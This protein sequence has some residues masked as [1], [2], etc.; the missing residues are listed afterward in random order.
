MLLPPPT[1]TC[2]EFSESQVYIPPPAPIPG[3]YRVHRTPYAREV[4]D[5]FSDPL[6][7]QVVIKGASQILK[8]TAII[9]MVAYGIAHRPSAMMLVQPKE[10]AAIT[11]S[12]ER[13]MP[14]INASPTLN[15]VVNT[16]KG[17][18]IGSTQKEIHFQNGSLVLVGA[19]S[20]TDLAS[21][22]IRYLFCDEVDRYPVSAGKEGDPVT[23]A[24]ARTMQY[25]DSKVVLVSSPGN[26]GTSRIDEAFSKT[27]QRY[28][29]V[30]CPKC[31]VFQ[32][33]VWEQ[34][35]WVQD[36]DDKGEVVRH[37]P[38][39]C[40]YLCS[41]SK[42]SHKWTDSDRWGALRSPEARW[43]ATAK[44]EGKAGFQISRLY[45]FDVKGL[46]ELVQKFIDS[47]A[48]PDLMRTFRNTIL[49]ECYSEELSIKTDVSDMLA[50]KEVYLDEVPDGVVLL[51]AAV[52]VQ[53]NRLEVLVVGW[54]RGEE[55]WAID[56]QVIAIEPEHPSAWVELEKILTK[57]WTR[58]DGHPFRIE[59]T[60]IDSGDGNRQHL[61]FQ[62]CQPREG[63][64]VRAIKGAKE[65]PGETRPTWKGV[66]KTNKA[67]KA[68]QYPVFTYLA[69]DQIYYRLRNVAAKGANYIHFPALVGENGRDPFNDE[70]FK[71][72]LFGEYPK[73]ET[74]ANRR[75][76]VWSERSSVR[77]EAFD[78]FVYNFASLRA[79]QSEKWILERL[80]GIVPPVDEAK[81][82]ARKGAVK[83][84]TASGSSP[85]QMPTA[86]KAVSSTGQRA[87][88]FAFTPMPSA[89][90]QPGRRY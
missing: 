58:R 12:K 39:T 38:D 66:P 16:H 81:A 45:S 20:P 6:C 34:V 59:H 51:T 1:M 47:Q 84:Q 53:K 11:F 17:S 71:Q 42:C 55:C 30:P 27:D 70:F 83:Q 33:M 43:V 78:L 86:A 50:R 13:L 10:G 46:A 54:G 4:L 77:N 19:E 9:N 36:I 90:G 5:C 65:Q 80:A 35:H 37:Y 32:R 61:V 62:F 79:L 57:A 3:I 75:G 7:K 23:L 40:Y 73:L 67:N 21:R 82:E 28:Y 89:R 24:I 85:V 18:K 69:K 44:F 63:R 74:R 72:L 49:G 2:T 31:N 29:N 48:T 52:D 76:R 26:L 88:R 64:R 56:H 8:T 87:P 25:W 22:P 41:N 60:C 68:L 14:V 15:R